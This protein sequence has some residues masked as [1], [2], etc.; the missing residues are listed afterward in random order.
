[1]AISPFIPGTY[2][3]ASNAR[4]LTE[5]RTTLDDLQRQLTTEKKSETHGGLGAQRFTSLQFQAKLSSVNAFRDT[6][7]FTNIRLSQMDLGLKQLTSVSAE[8]RNATINPTYQLGSTGQS[9]MQKYATERFREALDVLNLNADGVYFFAGRKSDTQPVLDLET[10]V[11]GDAA[12]RAGVKQMIVERKAADAGVAGSLGRVTRGGAGTTATLT[13]DG[14][15]PFGFKLTAA[16]STTASITAVR[17]AG[18]PADVTF[19]VAANPAQGSEVRVELTLPGGSTQVVSLT[20]YDPLAV[21]PGNQGGFAIGATPAA[22][23]ANLRAALAGALDGHASTTLPPASAL[24]ASNAFFAGNE[25]T[26]PQRIP[27]PA[28]T[29]TGFIPG[30]PADTVIWYRGDATSA[31]A[32]A[33]AQARIDTDITVNVGAQANELGIRRML[34]SLAVFTTETFSASNP[35]DKGRHEAMAGLLRAELSDSSMQTVA[36]IHLEVGL[37]QATMK[38]AD[39]RHKTTKAFVE[40]VIGGVENVNKE[41]AAARLLSLQTKMQAAYQTTSILSRLSLTDYLR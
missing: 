5:M 16:S 22:T 11:N 41:E 1:M 8:V 23:A 36:D 38:R 26:P 30:T 25:Q 13:E 39:D 17:T 27:A 6:I 18:P 24:A 12:G 19:N 28:A 40:D 31:S 37:A 14:T 4:M 7:Q 33:T 35:A 3:S 20:A 29:A 32:R 2:R 34:A 10:I 21:P 9:Q 15:H